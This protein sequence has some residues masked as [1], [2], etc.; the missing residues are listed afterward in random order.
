MTHSAEEIRDWLVTRVSQLTGVP[1]GELDV[2]APLAR[3]GLDSDTVG[4]GTEQPQ[5]R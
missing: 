5:V 2:R 1:S 4:R 3:S